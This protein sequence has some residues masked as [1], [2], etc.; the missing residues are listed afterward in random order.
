MSNRLTFKLKK[1]SMVDKNLQPIEDCRITLYGCTDNL[2]C[3]IINVSSYEEALE[4][5]SLEHIY[6]LLYLHLSDAEFNHITNVLSH[7]PIYYFFDKSF[8]Y[9]NR[10]KDVELD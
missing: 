7:N 1:E 5:I 9:R 6:E 3:E 10:N 2:W 4:L 8:D